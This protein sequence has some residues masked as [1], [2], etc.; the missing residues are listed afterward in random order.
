VA[1]NKGLVGSGSSIILLALGS[2]VSAWPGYITA[3]P[4]IVWGV[5]LLGCLLVLL[6]FVLRRSERTSPPVPSSTSATTNNNAPVNVGPFYIGTALAPQVS[7]PTGSKSIETGH[8]IP[9]KIHILGPDQKTLGFAL[10]N[11]WIRAADGDPGLLVWIENKPANVGSGAVPV[12]S[13][14]ASL[15]FYDLRGVLL[16]QV[17]RVYWLDQSANTVS[18]RSGESAAGIICLFEG[19]LLRTYENQSSNR[20]RVAPVPHEWL[21]PLSPPSDDIPFSTPIDVEMILVS[22]ETHITMAICR[23]R[24]TPTDHGC[25][26][27]LHQNCS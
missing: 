10:G 9:A 7:E 14:A 4:W 15:R 22:E 6:G 24:L 12:K 1:V 8:Q 18:L 3:N 25:V 16:H 13:L 21:T 11:M 27:L 17:S 5:L 2:V 23:L 20:Q 26:A 19:E